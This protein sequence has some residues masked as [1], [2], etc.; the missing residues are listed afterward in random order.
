MG[1]VIH[2][3]SQNLHEQIC[4]RSL[5]FPFNVAFVGKFVG[6]TAVKIEY[7]LEEFLKVHQVLLTVLNIRQATSNL[8]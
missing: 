6:G 1:N 3:L 2:P 5:K 8:V 7:S 4:L